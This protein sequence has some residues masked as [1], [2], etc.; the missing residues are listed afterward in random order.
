MTRHRH[1][2]PL[3]DAARRAGVVD[4]R[5][6]AA[7]EATPRQRFV[8]AE[9][10]ANADEDRP[11]PIGQEQTTSQP[12][13]IATMVAALELRGGERVLEVGTGFGYQTAILSRLAAEVY[14][15]DRAAA[16]T[17]QAAR[18]LAT[19]GV[20]GCHLE[21]GD[22]T[23]GLGAYAPYD[24]IIVSA[25]TPS[26]PA[27]L[28]RQLRVG[29]RLVAPVGPA[30]ATEVVVFEATRDGLDRVRRLVGAR[31]VPLVPDDHDPPP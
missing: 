29:G 8:P 30:G 12:S 7:I 2:P 14:S 21:V 31:F 22:G 10:R 5:V 27:A 23:R 26:V 24:A 4:E 19:A 13:L 25:A 3:V 18:N 17:D 9:Q 16:L 6:L 1:A 11:I 20:E 28:A 15:I